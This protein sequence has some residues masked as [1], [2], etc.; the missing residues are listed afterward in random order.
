MRD[1]PRRWFRN[2]GAHHTY[3]LHG[4]D[5]AERAI[6]DVAHLISRLWGAP[7]GRPV[8]R[9][10]MLIAWTAE[11]VTWAPPSRF[12]TVAPGELTCVLVLADPQDPGLPEYDAPYES[13]YYPCEWLWGPGTL[14]D[15]LAWHH[16]HQPASDQ[17]ETIDRLF[18]LQHDGDLLYIPRNPAVAAALGHD[19]QDGTWYLIRADSPS[20]AFNHQRRL[21]V[22]EPGHEP[23]GDCRAC[24]VETIGSGDLRQMLRRCAELGADVTPQPVPDVR[25]TMSRMPRCNRI[26]GNGAWD[27]P[28]T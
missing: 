24:P 21:L 1:E 25:V 4:P 6:A 7:A 18:L 15:A 28:S 13:T 5:H 19:D 26:L 9:E 2:N 14:P 11:Q 8:H 3:Q 12:T 17:A 16:Q 10:V 23:A 27:I 20:H 22:G